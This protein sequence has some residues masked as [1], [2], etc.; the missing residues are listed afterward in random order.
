[1]ASVSC[2]TT[3]AMVVLQEPFFIVRMALEEYVCTV[4]GRSVPYVNTV[5]VDSSCLGKPRHFAKRSVM[6]VRWLALSGSSRAGLVV[7]LCEAGTTA[8]CSKTYHDKFFSC[9]QSWPGSRN[10]CCGDDEV[11]QFLPFD[12]A[13]GRVT[14]VNLSRQA[15]RWLN[16][17]MC[18]IG[19]AVRH[20]Q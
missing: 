20:V 8:V 2:G 16:H 7:L 18:N 3:L 1:M 9:K 14:V 11:G 6:N 19:A 15:P 17:D 10:S 5:R 12:P 13:R 4:C